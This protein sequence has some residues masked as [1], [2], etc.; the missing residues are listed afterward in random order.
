MQVAWE[1]VPGEQYLP[2]EVPTTGQSRT[3]RNTWPDDALPDP[4][5]VSSECAMGGSSSGRVLEVRSFEHCHKMLWLKL[6]VILRR[7]SKDKLNLMER[8]LT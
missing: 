7:A 5:Q 6:G 8:G 1:I 4:N 2:S 3:S